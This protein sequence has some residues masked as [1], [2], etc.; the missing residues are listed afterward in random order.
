VKDVC[1]LL[2]VHPSTLYK[3]V[4][5]G[6]IP[7]FRVGIDWRFRRDVIERWTIEQSMNAQ[8]VR[9][10]IERQASMGKLAIGETQ[11]YV[12]LNSKAAKRMPRNAQL[13]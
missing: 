5:Q 2:Q 11:P 1:D 4:R 12:D 8:R 9:K 3:L 13:S 10:A 6:S 7:S